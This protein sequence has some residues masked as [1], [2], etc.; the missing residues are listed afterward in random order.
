M[1]TACAFNHHL[2]LEKVMFMYSRKDLRF[3]IKFL[4]KNKIEFIVRIVSFYWTKSIYCLHERP[5]NEV[6]TQYF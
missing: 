3:P 4:S 6:K 2:L 5:E 1:Y